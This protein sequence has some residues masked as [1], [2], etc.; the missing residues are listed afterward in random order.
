MG[1]ELVG[2]R[3]AVAIWEGLAKSISFHAAAVESSQPIRGHQIVGFAASVFVTAAFAQRE[4][5]NPQPGLNARLISSIASGQS[6]VLTGEQLARENALGSLHVVILQGNSAL[7]GMTPTQSQ[8]VL[9]QVTLACLSFLDGYQ[10]RQALNEGTSAAEIETATSFPNWTV[11]SRFED[12]HRK[13]PR[14]SWNRDRA[15][16]AI[17]FAKGPVFMVMGGRQHE[18]ILHFRI[19]DQELLRAALNGLTDSEL[20]EDLG[21][22]LSALKKRWASI[23]DRVQ[24]ARPDLLP[25]PLE[26]QSRGPQKRHRLLA[27]LRKHPEELRPFSKAQTSRRQP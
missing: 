18:P 13:N 7:E 16:L 22:K 26:H 6:A 19:A 21:L 4:T 5:A 15:L 12:F 8:A 11:L 20:S 27:Y 9:K 24:V 3:H 10:I 17:E 25:S 2:R 1:H 14:N 23:F